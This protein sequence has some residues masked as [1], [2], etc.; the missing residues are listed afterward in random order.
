LG[1]FDAKGASVVAISV[2]EQKDSAELATKLG[3]TYPL[4]SDTKQTAIRAFGVA[5]ENTGVAWPTVF[6]VGRDGKIARRFFTESY[7]KRATTSD[8]LAA[9]DRQR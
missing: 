8:V 3:L 6:V 9:V 2:D 4:L 1:E 5:D 7:K